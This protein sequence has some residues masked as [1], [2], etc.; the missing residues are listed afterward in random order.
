MSA[1]HIGDQGFYVDRARQERADAVARTG[2]LV[3][4]GVAGVLGALPS[5]GREVAARLGRWRERRAATRA[6]LLL[7]DR[8]LKDIGITRSEVRAA[9]N[10]TLRSRRFVDTAPA[11]ASGDVALSAYAIAGCNDNERP[12]HAA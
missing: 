9:V 4:A 6:L 3:I 8:M 11:A 10:G 5:L 1:E 2:H 7:D 12:R